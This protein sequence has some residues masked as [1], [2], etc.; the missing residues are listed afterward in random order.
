M[1]LLRTL[2]IV[3]WLVVAWA[4]F[5][6]VSSL[7]LGAAGDFFLGDM[8]HPWRGQFNLDFLAH[9]LL[10]GLWLGWSAKNKWLGPVIVIC[11]AVGGG[12]FSLAYLLVRSF[13]GDRNIGHVLLGRHHTNRTA[14]K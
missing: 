4:T 9:L 12:L 8:S 10:T 1:N 13:G 3:G 7:G 14:V 6:G 2:L 11:A 5:R